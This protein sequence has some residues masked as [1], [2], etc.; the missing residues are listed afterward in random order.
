MTMKK[1]KKPLTIKEQKNKYRALQWGMFAGEYVAVASPYVV[2]GAINYE[3]WFMNNP[4]GWQIG[5]GGGIALALMGVIVAVITF[6]KENDSKITDGYITLILTW[7]VVATCFHLL[8]D[9]IY[10]ISTIMYIGAIGLAGA[11]GLNLASKQMK[12]KADKYLEAMTKAQEDLDK[13]QA[14]QEIEE[15]KVKV[16]VK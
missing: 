9:I 4:N 12:K 7:L 16:R 2:M 10:Q 3:E 6:K 1:E 14:R 13:D 8:A 11:F 5:V 15:E